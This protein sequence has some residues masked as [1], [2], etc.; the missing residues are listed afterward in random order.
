MSVNRY[1]FLGG[2]AILVLAALIFFIMETSSSIPIAIG[3]A[4]VGIALIANSLKEM[5]SVQIS[6][7]L[8]A[9]TISKKEE[10][11]VF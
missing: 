11:N 5:I 1:K 9:R 2:V 3:L 8:D 6:I 10:S 7:V 4:M